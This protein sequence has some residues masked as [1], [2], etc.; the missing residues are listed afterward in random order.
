MISDSKK[1]AHISNDVAGK[2]EGFKV[3]GVIPFYLKYIRIPVMVELSVILDRI[4]EIKG[5]SD[6]TI[7][8]IFNSKLMVEIM[9]LMFE[10]VTVGLVNKTFLGK[11]FKPL[12]KRKVKQCSAEQ[13]RNLYIVIQNLANYAFFFDMYKHMTIKTHVVLRED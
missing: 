5:D 2:I 6:V 3:L 4:K 11:L 7:D 10:Y 8:D 1:I 9:P 13:L 12:I